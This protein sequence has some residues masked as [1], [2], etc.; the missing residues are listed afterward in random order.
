MNTGR[1]PRTLC[2]NWRQPT[3]Q[4][5]IRAESFNGFPVILAADVLY[6]SPD[7]DPLIELIDRLLAPDGVLWLAEPGRKTSERF[8]NTVALAG[9]RGESFYSEGP[10]PDG[11]TTRVGIHLLQRPPGAE[12]L[13]DTLGG[14]RT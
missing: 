12:A 1:S 5:T 3:T 7:I 11:T 10:W 14:W 6:E 2:V 8:L 4:A 13:L 9:W